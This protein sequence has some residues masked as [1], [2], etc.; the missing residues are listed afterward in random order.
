MSLNKFMHPRNPFYNNPPDFK[1]L[2]KL[3]PEFSKIFKNN[4]I[5]FKDPEA[6]RVLCCTLMK[7]IF[8]TL[9]KNNYE[10]KKKINSNFN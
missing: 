10:I 3:F 9:I 7:H 8:G 5:D 2:A 1:Q 6:L 4:F